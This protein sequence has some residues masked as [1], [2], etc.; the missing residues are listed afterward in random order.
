MGLA[1]LSGRI[2]NFY[3]DLSAWNVAKAKVNPSTQ[4]G[5]ATQET[6]IQFRTQPLAS[7][8]REEHCSR[9][10]STETQSRVHENAGLELTNK[11]NNNT[12]PNA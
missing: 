11:E 3:R 1:P 12:V 5:G 9:I 8:N 7:L 4:I 2:S 10:W 6:P